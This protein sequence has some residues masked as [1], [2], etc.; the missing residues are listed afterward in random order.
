MSRLELEI[1]PNAYQLCLDGQVLARLEGGPAA[2]LAGADERLRDLDIEA[3]IE[4][5]ED[6]LMPS[7]KSWQGLVLHVRDIPGRLRDR[8]GADAILTPEKVERA[9]SGAVD[10]V[11]FGRP[12]AR[13]LVADMVLLREQVHHGGL[14][15][16][17]LE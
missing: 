12:I 2:L 11:V 9:F 4:R 16:I 17:E 3:A 8:L 10:D 5:S 6:W 13:D 1:H 15:R 14:S 7:S